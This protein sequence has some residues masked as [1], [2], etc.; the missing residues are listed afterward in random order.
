MKKI[1]SDLLL[2]ASTSSNNV[3]KLS[4]PGADGTEWV[5]LASLGIL[6]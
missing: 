2:L 3:G 4:W 6:Y 1:R 5:S